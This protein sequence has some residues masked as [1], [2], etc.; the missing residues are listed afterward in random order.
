MMDPVIRD[1]LTGAGIG[2]GLWLMRRFGLFSWRKPPKD[3]PP[4]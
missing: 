1:I 3:P 4:E 2:L